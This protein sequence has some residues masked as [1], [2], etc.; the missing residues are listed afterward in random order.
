M[1]MCVSNNSNN[2][3]RSNSSRSGST[4]SNSNRETKVEIIREY[5][6]VAKNRLLLIR[7]TS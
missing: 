4:C 5:N 1:C 2:S 7:E 3:K 6:E